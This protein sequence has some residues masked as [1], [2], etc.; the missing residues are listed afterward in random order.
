MLAPSVGIV[1]PVS[2]LADAEAAI[3]AGADELYCGALFD[4]AVAIFGDGE[5]LSRRQGRPAHVRTPDELAAIAALGTS[6]GHRVALT[7]NGRYSSSEQP[8]ILE[9][10][11]TWEAM[12]GGT[13][14][15]ADPAL[16]VWLHERCPRLSVHL[17]LLAGVFN[18]ASA[19]LF[20]SLGVTRIVLPR[21][22]CIDEMA[23]ITAAVPEVEYEAL[24][25]HQKCRFVDGMCGFYHGVRIPENVPADFAY[26]RVAG[27]ELAVAWCDDPAYE[28]HGCEL[29]WVAGEERALPPRCDDV[30]A[31][32]C[33]AC[34]IAALARAGVHHLKI[35]GRGFPTVLITRAVRFLRLAVGIWDRAKSEE[36][37]R[38]TVITAYSR[39][40]GSSCDADRC[41]YRLNAEGDW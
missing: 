35:A 40:F 37:A 3:A 9:L 6:T 12:G 24:A 27:T 5:V 34:Q 7:L 25:L 11:V 23:A 4:D 26:E 10:A 38:R 20:A 2:S 30:G 29:A 19:R 28:G 36:G 17:S 39:A 22:L 18:S 14:M 41:Y 31:P 21:D 8:R 1:A 32:H 13:V 15:V 16:I 33:A